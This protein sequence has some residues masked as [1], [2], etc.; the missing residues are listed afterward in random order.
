MNIQL[1]TGAGMN[2]PYYVMGKAQLRIAP[3]HDQWVWVDPDSD[4]F[5]Q[6]AAQYSAIKAEIGDVEEPW[7]DWLAR[8]LS[9]DPF[10]V[11]QALSLC[12]QSLLTMATACTEEFVSR[13]PTIEAELKHKS[14]TVLPADILQEAVRANGRMFGMTYPPGKR[15]WFFVS[16]FHTLASQQP[17]PHFVLGAAL[18]DDRD[19]LLF[20]INHEL[21]IA[22][23]EPICEEERVANVLPIVDEITRRDRDVRGKGALLEAVVHT[24]HTHEQGG[25]NIERYRKPYAEGY[26][27]LLESLWR[28]RH[29]LQQGVAEFIVQSVAALRWS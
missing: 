9:S 7:Y 8:V 11:E 12:P 1:T 28:H 21:A 4:P 10:S 17:G 19:H 6:F 24:V 13:W 29:L 20:T 16:L 23:L 5:A 3:F 22:L 27:Q 2:L 26:W 14:E 18:L 25:S 15:L